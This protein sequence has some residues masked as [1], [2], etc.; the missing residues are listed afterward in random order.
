MTCLVYRNEKDVGQGIKKSGI[1]RSDIFV[2]T[3]V[4]GDDH[5][6]E[7]CKEAFAKSLRKYADSLFYHFFSNSYRDKHFAVSIVWFGHAAVKECRVLI[8]ILM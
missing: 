5:G 6:P 3:K 1:P 8:L 2:V 4:W 7:R